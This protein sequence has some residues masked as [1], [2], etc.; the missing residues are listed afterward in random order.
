MRNLYVP[1]FFFPFFI[2]FGRNKLQ[3]NMK[4]SSLLFYLIPF[5]SSR[6]CCFSSFNKIMWSMQKSRPENSLNVLLSLK[7]IEGLKP[8]INSQYFLWFD[9]L[10]SLKFLIFYFMCLWWILKVFMPFMHNW[11]TWL[12]LFFFF[13]N[14]NSRV[15]KNIK[16]L[17]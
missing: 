17:M 15:M 6:L 2:L 9:V 1:S 8:S 3:D 14:W 13:W 4:L 5:S 10:N 7:P 12:I 16:I 11:N